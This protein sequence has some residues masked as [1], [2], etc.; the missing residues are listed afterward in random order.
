MAVPCRLDVY[1]GAIAASWGA[2]N[3]GAFFLRD[4]VRDQ[5]GAVILYNAD[6]E[7]CGPDTKLEGE[8]FARALT[9]AAGKAV[10]VSFGASPSGTALL[11]MARSA[12]HVQLAERLARSDIGE[13]ESYFQCLVGSEVKFIT[14]K[15]SIP[16]E[17]W[18]QRIFMKFADGG[19]ST[20][21]MAFGGV[22]TFLLTAMVA[23]PP[24]DW[25]RLWISLL[26]LALGL[27][28]GCVGQSFHR[29]AAVKV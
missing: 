25:G 2:S 11:Y 13:H 9:E 19:F 28:V 14:Y 4:A 26:L 16:P 15:L 10:V 22:L 23:G 17:P 6:G 5:R 3:E 20:A 12:S 1:T 18:G 21:V 7:P 24:I 8:E 27:A 29:R